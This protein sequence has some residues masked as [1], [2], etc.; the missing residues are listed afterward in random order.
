MTRTYICIKD[1]P[2]THIK[3]GDEIEIKK[4]DN[5]EY[6]ID[7][8]IQTTAEIT[9]EY[10]KKKRLE[11]WQYSPYSHSKIETWVSCPK[12][13]EWNYII[14]PPRVEMPSPILE[15]G[16]L[17]HA[18]LE[19][20]INDNLENFDIPDQFKALT[21]KDCEK[22]IE[23]ALDF[24]ET[25][26]IYK[27][28]KNLPGKKI[29]EQEIFLGAKLEPV[30]TLE[31]SLIRGFIDLLVYDEKT[32][33]C[34]I[35]DWK[36]G[37]KS[38]EDLKKWPKPKDQLELYAVW[39][40]QVFGAD[41]IETAFVYVEH[42]HMAKYIFEGSDIASL[43]KKFKDKIHNIE[44]DNKFVKNL[45]QL[46]LWCDFKEICIGIPSNVDPRSLTKDDV[47]NSAKAFSKEQ[48][49]TP[50]TNSKNSNFLAKIRDKSTKT[51]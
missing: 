30:E 37:G 36:T 31:V 18:V 9:Y 23:Q 47:F 26:S 12:K 17:F 28:I 39:A 40:N 49:P 24:A 8:A 15:K 4:L 6:I 34:Y 13:F 51:S 25:S 5:G 43:K 1:F 3:V 14:K 38:K 32:N 16:T 29:P 21:S 10:F 19:F 45:S 42:D 46:C 22:I 11:G 33:A 20:H 2:N 50:I 7:G 44:T 27:W 48:K 35:F 41:Y